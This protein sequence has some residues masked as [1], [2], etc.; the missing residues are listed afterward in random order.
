M[1]VNEPTTRVDTYNDTHGDPIY[2]YTIQQTEYTGTIITLYTLKATYPT[3]HTHTLTP[4]ELTYT[5]NIY[6]PKITLE[7]QLPRNWIHTP[8]PRTPKG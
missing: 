3:Q 2:L 1:T 8:T 7:T 5:P 4:T 6:T